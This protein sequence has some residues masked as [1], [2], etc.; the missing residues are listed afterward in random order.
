MHLL[1]AHSVS[2]H[3][4]GTLDRGQPRLQRE[5]VAAALLPRFGRFCT[6]NDAIAD[7]VHWPS[8]NP[9]AEASVGLHSRRNDEHTCRASIVKNGCAL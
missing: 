4:L 3:V 8:H 2:V 9:V 1:E 5:T 7:V 6:E